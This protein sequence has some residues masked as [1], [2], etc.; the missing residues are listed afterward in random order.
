MMLVSDNLQI[1]HPDIDRAVRTLDPAPIQD[2]VRRCVAAGAD[3][4][5]IN[6]GPLV[7]EPEKKMAFLV[8]A[9]RSVTDLPVFLDTTN[10]KA[11]EAG[12]RAA[13][14]R[15][16]INGFSLEPAKLEY[17]LPLAGK[18]DVDIIGYLLYPNSH[19]PGD[20]SERLGVAVTLFEAFQKAGGN[21]ERLIID[22]IV[23]PV[24]W[25]NGNRQ[26]MAILSVIR[27]LPDL[28]GF[29]VRT[30]AGLSNLTTGPGPRDRKR[31]LE[32]AYL[33]MLAEAGL[34]M[35]LMNVLHTET[36]QTARAC[37]ALIGDRI[38]TWAGW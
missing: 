15:T 11:M 29:P 5:D 8:A 7:R 34:T 20:E 30:V 10:P 26:N 22:P 32:A 13:K 33:P 14:G 36:V 17:I 4:I 16:V 37:E 19:V 35:A 1:T 3:A 25:E 27:T 9:V 2:L 12:L 31:R 28:L 38:F 6:S 18:Y 24:M 21:P 23:A